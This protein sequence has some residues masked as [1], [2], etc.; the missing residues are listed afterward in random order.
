M[1][2]LMKLLFDTCN[3]IYIEKKGVMSHL[4]MGQHP[5]QRRVELYSESLYAT[6]TGGK[7]RANGPLCRYGDYL[8]TSS[9]SSFYCKQKEFKIIRSSQKQ[10][11]RLLNLFRR[12]GQILSRELYIE[13]FIHFEFHG[14]ILYILLQAMSHLNQILRVTLKTTIPLKTMAPMNY[15][16]QK[17]SLGL[18]IFFKKFSSPLQHSRTKLRCTR[19]GTN[20][21]IFCLTATSEG[22]IAGMS[23][24]TTFTV[25]YMI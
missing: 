6:E 19:W 23:Q 12:A 5:I 9:H 3:E 15:L 14:S 10:T 22:L 1:K 11:V 24:I 4:A 2:K 20:I 18:I 16:I 7:C 13:L 25:S 21:M 8:F 17:R